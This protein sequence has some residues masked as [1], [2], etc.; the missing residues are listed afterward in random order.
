M[1]FGLAAKVVLPLLLLLL[2]F[3]MPVLSHLS[4]G[5]D[6]SGGYFLLQLAVIG[7]EI[8]VSSEFGLGVENNRFHERLIVRWKVIV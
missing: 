4:R 8:T 5:R 1:V 7:W 6:I 2:W 3:P